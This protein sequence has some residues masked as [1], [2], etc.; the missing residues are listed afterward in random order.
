[1]IWQT[2]HLPKQKWANEAQE[3]QHQFINQQQPPPPQAIQ[4][5][6]RSIEE[7]NINKDANFLEY[8]PTNKKNKSK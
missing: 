2:K 6:R 4:H 3:R 5:R 7:I 1:V 8:K